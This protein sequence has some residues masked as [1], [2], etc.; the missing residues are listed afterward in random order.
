MNIHKRLATTFLCIGV[1]ISPL[2]AN[3]QNVESPFGRTS[4]ASDC[5]P[6]PS[7]SILFRGLGASR[8]CNHEIAPQDYIRPDYSPEKQPTP[9]RLHEVLQQNSRDL[10]KQRNLYRG[11]LDPYTL[12]PI[13]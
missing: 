4:S 7:R 2:V 10:K 13:R 6:P 8:F 11:E 3:A 1:T 5:I 12:E 9:L